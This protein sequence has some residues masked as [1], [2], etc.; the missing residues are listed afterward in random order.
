MLLYVL[1]EV[2]AL[3]SEIPSQK[4]AGNLPTIYPLV[5]PAPAH[6]QLLAYLLD[7]KKLLA[8]FLRLLVLKSL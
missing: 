3:Y 4:H 6:P 1:I 2:C 7:C 8:V 5:D